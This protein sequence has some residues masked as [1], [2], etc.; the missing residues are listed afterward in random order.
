[1][2]VMFVMGRQ[3]WTHKHNRK[4]KGRSLIQKQVI[5]IQIHSQ[6]KI[7]GKQ[8]QRNKQKQGLQQKGSYTRGIIITLEKRLDSSTRKNKTIWHRTQERH[9]L[10]SEAN[11]AQV[12]HIKGGASRENTQGQEVSLGR[13]DRLVTCQNKTGN[14][15][16]KKT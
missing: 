8:I 10:N 9:R 11:K 12:R 13:Q 1:M 2:T 5:H 6:S 15:A 14:G 4:I 3:V 16:N 7:Q